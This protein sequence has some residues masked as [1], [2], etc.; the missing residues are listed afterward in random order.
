VNCANHPE[1]AAAAYCRECGK[2][3]C[4]ECIRRARGSVFCAEHAPEATEPSAAPPAGTAAGF[5]PSSFTSAAAPFDAGTATSHEAQVSPSPYTVTASSGYHPGVPP[6]IALLL[7]FIPGV[8]AICNGQYA[9]GLIHAVI[10]GLLVS[11]EASTHFA[12]VN[13]ICGIM[14]AA[15]VFYM[16]FEAFHTAARRRRG[17]PVEEFSSIFELRAAHNRMPLG[18]ILLVVVGFILLL[19]TTDIVSMEVF[20]RYWPVGLIALGI[21][22]LYARVHPDRGDGSEHDLELRQ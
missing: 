13:I 16:A 12:P 5:A 3:L 21:Y 15:W 18:A 9:K 7:G 20:A 1:T 11:A 19:Q 4:P 14:I 17:L 8:G 2:P 6:V 22:L 10:F